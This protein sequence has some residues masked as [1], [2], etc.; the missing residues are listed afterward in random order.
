MAKVTKMA[1]EVAVRG[2]AP[3]GFNATH[4]EDQ[5]VHGY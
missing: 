4:P 1:R 5:K 3:S 2:F